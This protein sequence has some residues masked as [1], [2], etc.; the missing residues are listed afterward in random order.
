[1]LLGW[2]MCD[3]VCQ[4]VCNGPSN[5]LRR[6]CWPGPP[7]RRETS[8]LPHPV[9][10][11]KKSSGKV[12]YSYIY[13]KSTLILIIAQFCREAEERVKDK[14]AQIAREKLN[15]MI[16]REKQLQLERKRKALA[17]LNQIKGELTVNRTLLCIISSISTR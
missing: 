3:Q 17:F 11:R 15:G 7:G 16:S 1:M 14:L 9:P 13:I 4:I 5:R 8:R 6:S 10:H 12:R 2:S